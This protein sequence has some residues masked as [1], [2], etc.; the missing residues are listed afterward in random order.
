MLRSYLNIYIYEVI[1]KLCKLGQDAVKVTTG[2]KE[3]AHAG[4]AWSG[5]G[6]RDRGPAQAS[7]LL[8]WLGQSW[9][10][11]KQGGRGAG[12]RGSLGLAEPPHLEWTQAGRRVGGAWSGHRRGGAGAGAEVRPQQPEK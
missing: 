10:E 2:Q 3:V 8:R 5:D 4:E 11:H 6:D 12:G 9:S 1:C 7:A